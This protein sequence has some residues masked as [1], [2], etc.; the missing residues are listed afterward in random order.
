MRRAS[1]RA[2]TRTHGAS[3]RTAA[4]PPLS[5]P[6]GLD[7]DVLGEGTLAHMAMRAMKELPATARA[8]MRKPS[9]ACYTPRRAPFRRA[10]SND[11]SEFIQK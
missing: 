6:C 1:H 2:A 11:S 4:G 7:E 3:V 5:V 10:Q 9:G 8:L